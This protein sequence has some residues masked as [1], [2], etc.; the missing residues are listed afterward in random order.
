M[1]MVKGCGAAHGTALS[2]RASEI[3]KKSRSVR[4]DTDAGIE[5]RSMM[6][7]SVSSRASFLTRNLNLGNDAAPSCQVRALFGWFDRQ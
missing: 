1:T 4:V 6:S 2:I 3:R 7:G 5:A